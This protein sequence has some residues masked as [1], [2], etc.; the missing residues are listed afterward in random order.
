MELL[1]DLADPRVPLTQACDAL[2]VSRATL[3]RSTCL[4][5]PPTCGERAP[6]A[7]RLSDEERSAIMAV[8]HSEEFADQPPAEVYAALLS[9]GIYLASTRTM[10]R[11]LD[12]IGETQE[13]RSQRRPQVHPKPSLTATAPNQIWTWDIT[14]LATERVGVY[15]HAYVIIDLFS[16]Y[17][18]G[19]M[20][21][22]K[23][24][25]H[26]A[27][28]LFAETM[29][30][31]GIEPGLLVHSDRG[32]AMKS[33]TLAQLLASLGATRSFSRP[34]VSDD[35]PFSEAGFKTMKY[36]PDYPGRFGSLLHARA[37]LAEFFGWANYGHHHSGLA[38]FTPADVFFGRV[39]AV[40][41]VRQ[42]ALDAAFA[43][44]PERFPNG[45]PTVPLPPAEVSINPLTSHVLGAE[46]LP[47][48]PTA[49]EVPQVAFACLALPESEVPAGGALRPSSA[50]SSG[51]RP[52]HR[53]TG[54]SQ[55]P[56]ATRSRCGEHGE[57]GQK[58]PLTDARTSAPCS[59]RWADTVPNMG[60]IAT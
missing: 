13:R 14:K 40:R 50:P 15:L 18:V 48:A 45:V 11:L 54:P 19:W 39:E 21:A 32:S 51:V 49:T 57:D 52:Q 34:R 56:E 36:Q 60:Q 28:Q 20:V 59:P 46:H 44:H 23:E 1:E 35:N 9:R 38:F 47:G 53:S 58:A 12:E 27:A 3:Y 10:Y 30:R 7:R 8:L 42:A 25:K 2:G 17:V 41:C 26:L 16:R 55:A 29:A 43:A 31:H 33:D 5:P 6:S 24:C 37:W 22:D 4:P